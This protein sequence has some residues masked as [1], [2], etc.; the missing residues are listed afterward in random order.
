MGHLTREWVDQIYSAS[1]KDGRKWGVTILFNKLVYFNHEKTTDDKEGRYVM[2]TGTIGGTKITMLNLCATNE[3]CTVFFFFYIA[4]LLANKAERTI[5]IGGDFSC[6]LRQT[7]DRLPSEVGFLYKKSPTG[8]GGYL[9]S[10]TP[11]RKLYFHV[12]GLWQLL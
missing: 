11:Q 3:D 10:L 5:L 7:M 1:F 8:H 12:T 9:V 2:V 6:V 4:S